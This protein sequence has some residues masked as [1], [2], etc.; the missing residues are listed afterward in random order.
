MKQSKWKKVNKSYSAASSSACVASLAKPGLGG[1]VG[2]HNLPATFIGKAVAESED[3]PVKDM[4]RL[5]RR[6]DAKRHDRKA[7]K[8]AF[9]DWKMPTGE[10][11]RAACNHVVAHS[12]SVR[13][14]V[15]ALISG[16]MP[17]FISSGGALNSNPLRAF[18]EFVRFANIEAALA[19]AAT[20]EAHKVGLR[21]YMALLSG[22]SIDATPEVQRAY[23]SAIADKAIQ[24][25]RHAIPARKAARK[26]ES[27]RTKFRSNKR[28]RNDQK[29]SIKVVTAM[30]PRVIERIGKEE[31]VKSCTADGKVEY[32]VREI[33]GKGGIPFDTLG[34]A[35]KHANPEYKAA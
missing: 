14:A 22:N 19:D 26:G 17:R 3:A 33:G 7:I 29:P 18:A 11:S 9:I 12:D 24:A 32:L 13:R 2:D 28:R 4:K 5:R 25:M 10:I 20:P 31:I 8:V 21:H 27:D 30:P 6:H 15:C 23:H 34:A 16:V 35:R 1:I